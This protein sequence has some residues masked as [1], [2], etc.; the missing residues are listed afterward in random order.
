MY[1]C[2]QQQATRP[3]PICC[4]WCSIGLCLWLSRLRR[5]T[6]IPAL[7]QGSYITVLLPVVQFMRFASFVTSG[8]FRSSRLHCV[9]R[10]LLL[11]RDG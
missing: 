5:I 3:L 11:H 10:G 7:L 6:G 4:L 2:E 9:G 8:S 1:F